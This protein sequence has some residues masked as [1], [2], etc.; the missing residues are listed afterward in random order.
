MESSARTISL[1][2]EDEG[3][4]VDL[5]GPPAPLRGLLLLT[6]V[7]S[8]GFCAGRDLAEVAGG[9]QAAIER[10]MQGPVR[11]V[12]EV[13]LECR[14]PTVAAIFGHTLGGGAELALACDIRTAPQ[15]VCGSVFQR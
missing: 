15:T 11:N 6:G 13:I 9:S 3:P 7:G 12:F 14:K 8:R 5:P 4:R 10:P 2:D 1:S